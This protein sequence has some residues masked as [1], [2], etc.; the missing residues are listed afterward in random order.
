MD[1]SGIEAAHLK[2]HF[3][4]PVNVVERWLMPQVCCCLRPPTP[5]RTNRCKLRKV[6]KSNALNYRK[7]LSVRSFPSDSTRRNQFFGW[8]GLVMPNWLN[9][10]EAGTQKR[11]LQSWNCSSPPLMS[12]SRPRLGGASNEPPPS[13]PSMF[14]SSHI[15]IARHILGVHSTRFVAKFTSSQTWILNFWNLFLR[16]INHLSSGHHFLFSRQDWS[17]K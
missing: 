9:W 7:S 17:I 12:I 1:D 5:R 6:F 2:R 15:I 3:G 8:Q 4:L 14:G 13:P 10:K 16:K 11:E